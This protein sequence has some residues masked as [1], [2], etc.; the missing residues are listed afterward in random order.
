MILIHEKY[1]FKRQMLR[2]K[3]MMYL[4]ISFEIIQLQSVLL[5]KIITPHP[6]LAGWG[7][8]I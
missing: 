1:A 6:W 4:R 7:I 5:V 3:L 8:L 2:H